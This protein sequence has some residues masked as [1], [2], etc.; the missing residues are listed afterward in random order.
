MALAAG[1]SLRKLVQTL[2]ITLNLIKI[3]WQL[4][5]S[6]GKAGNSVKRSLALSRCAIARSY[7]RN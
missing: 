6:F 7:F 5:R 1:S 3:P 4:H 2:R